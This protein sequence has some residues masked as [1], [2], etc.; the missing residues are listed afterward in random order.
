MLCNLAG[1]QPQHF[2]LKDLKHDYCSFQTACTNVNTSSVTV[3]P[4]VTPHLPWKFYAN[5]FSG[6]LVIL[7]TKK[8]AT[9]H[10]AVSPNW[11]KI[12]SRRPM[13]TPHLPWKF[14]ANRSSRFLVSL[15]TKKQT[16]KQ[17]DRKQYPVTQTYDKILVQITL[18]H[19]WVILTIWH[20]WSKN[21]RIILS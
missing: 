3:H 9:Q 12:E 6:L 21:F 19:S 11:P 13:V 16:N 8:L 5:Q 10:R 20:N 15:L 7:L 1:K 4:M 2:L 14:H 17:I 18:W